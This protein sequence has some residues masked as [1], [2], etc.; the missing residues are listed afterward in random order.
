ML[1]RVWRKGTFLHC[2]WEGKLVQPLWKTVWGF[3]KKLKLELLYNLAVVL[4]GI[5]PKKIV[6]PKKHMHLSVHYSTIYNEQDIK[7]T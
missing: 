3:L 6:I 7:A 2:W 1:E 4:L 5:Y